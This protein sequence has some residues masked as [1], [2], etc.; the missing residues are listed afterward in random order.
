MTRPIR[1]RCLVACGAVSLAWLVAA[2]TAQEAA[3]APPVPHPPAGV[4]VSSH[5]CL[6]CHNGLT[7]PAGEDVSIGAAWR[8]S[9]MANSSR[10]PYWQAAV[11]RETI[12]HPSA[13]AVIEDECSVCHMPMPRTLAHQAGGEG[14][15]F[16]HLPPATGAPGIAGLAADGVSC[17]VCHQIEAERLGTPESFTGGYVIKAAGPGLAATRPLYGP[18]DVDAGRTL[19]MRSVTGFTPARGPHVQQSELCASCHTLITNALGPQGEVVGE[20]PEQVPYLEWQHSD[21]AAERSCQACHMPPVERATPIAAVLGEPREGLARHTF[22]GGN[23]FMLRMLNRYREELGV[24]ATAQ[25]LEASAQATL[26]QL[27]ADAA[28]LTLARAEREGVRLAVDLDVVDRAGHKLP[29]GYPSRRAWL[30]LTVRDGAG[31]VVFESGALEPSG[32]I[33]GNDG[34]ADA[35]RFESHHAEI[36]RA[37]DVQIYEAVMVDAT[38]AVTTGLLRGVRFVKDNRLLPRGFDKASAEPRIQVRGAAAADP[39]F[40]GGGD[41]VRYRIELAA[42]AGPFAVE[43]RLLYQSIAYRWAHNLAPDDAAETRRVVGFY[44]SMSDVT[45]TELARTDAVVP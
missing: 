3:P 23:V 10:D 34:D 1:I 40:A 15:I 11:R 33:V 44:E 35:S 32:A 38:G 14:R 42:A 27:Q 30:H 13:V 37:E 20:L 36:T 22:V 29:T 7:T 41:R 26:R 21:F 8:G 43:A 45:A 9:M 16:E 39:D 17:T 31:R 2:A 6:A 12:D 4:F 18:R 19:V 25:E 5:E 28:T 24:E